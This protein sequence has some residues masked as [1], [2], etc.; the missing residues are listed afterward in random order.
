MND[1]TKLC[2]VHPANTRQIQWDGMGAGKWLGIE[3]HQKNNIKRS[4]EHF[5]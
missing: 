3:Q 2:N 4:F 5:T 1:N